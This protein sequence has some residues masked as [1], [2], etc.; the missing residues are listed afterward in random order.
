MMRRLLAF[1]V[2]L[3]L[4]AY[5]GA[6]AAYAQTNL[7]APDTS[8][9][10]LLDLIKDSAS[11]WDSA[12]RGYA[13]SLF[14]S[15]ATIQFVITFFPVAIRNGDLSEIMGELIRFILTIGFFAALLKYSNSWAQAIVDS[16]RQAGASAASLGGTGLSPGDMFGT[17]VEL[18][19]TIADVE[20]WNPFSAV[21]IALSSVIVLLCFVFIA[22]LMAVTLIESYIVINASVLFMGFGGS[23]WTREYAVALLRYA[24][25]V[26]A[27]L[28]VLTLLVGIVLSSAK[29][30]AGAYNHDDASMWTM[31][32]LGL[33]CAYLCKTIPDL[34]Q[35][36]ITGVSPG[37]GSNIGSMAAIAA[38]AAT[39]GAA[40][41]AGGAAGGAAGAAGGSAGGGAGG[42]A[43]GG[44]GGGTGP[45]GGAGGLAQG[46][47]NSLAAPA[48]SGVSSAMPEGISS[49]ARSGGQ[50]TGGGG[51]SAPTPPPADNTSTSPQA[52]G[53]TS[54]DATQGQADTEQDRR[55]ETQADSPDTAP[56]SAAGSATSAGQGASSSNTASQLQAP[57]APP[58]AP[59]IDGAD[60]GQGA[61]S[62]APQ[63]DNGTSL[64]SVT[65]SGTT[66][67]GQ[68]PAP[69]SDSPQADGAANKAGGKAASKK[70]AIAAAA[71]R[72]SGM[73]SALS[74]PGMESAA[75]LSIGP[76]M[77]SMPK[78]LD[79]D[80]LQESDFAQSD[81]NII[82]PHTPPAQDT[83]REPP[84]PPVEQS[85][86]DEK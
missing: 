38:V 82:E 34:I 84:A 42:A 2:V 46:I 75:G 85:E 74:V 50:R 63:S 36:L 54:D 45:L 43:G 48:R 60:T 44:A 57:G 25:A 17:A 39:A 26:G 29:T 73:L 67:P 9:Q 10:G 20:T 80:P 24:V 35:G 6:G 31:V 86:G 7:A 1:G 71:V 66:E 41:I 61:V 22:A 76:G 56:A 68:A 37:G 11:N 33:V 14:W 19:W 55:A 65:Q 59:T 8:V 12:L 18:A 47:K 49:A 13:S 27:K 70:R 21:A 28:F 16:F 30:W 78:A 64:P 62:D 72:G 40:A 23:Q 32:G 83:A 53:Q 5:V 51:A 81:D 58:Q 52:P 15:L 3:F 69:A 4:L 79:D 77:P